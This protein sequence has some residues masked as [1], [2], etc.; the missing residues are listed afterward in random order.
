M[1]ALQR[2]WS[3]GTEKSGYDQHGSKRKQR[4]KYASLLRFPSA[5]CPVTTQVLLQLRLNHI[6]L[7][8]SNSDSSW[9]WELMFSTPCRSCWYSQRCVCAWLV[10]CWKLWT[11]LNFFYF[12][13]NTGLKKRAV[14]VFS[15]HAIE[16]IQCL[17]WNNEA[18]GLEQNGAGWWEVE[19]SIGR[20]ECE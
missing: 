4:V 13:F 11:M 8:K 18:Q 1:C 10:R 9:Y 2:H 3:R 16:N 20:Q 19:L 15:A 5:Y 12:F 17:F 7:W 14:A 6:F